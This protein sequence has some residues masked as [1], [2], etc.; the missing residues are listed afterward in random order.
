[1]IAADLWPHRVNAAATAGQNVR[2]CAL[3]QQVPA[4]I[5]LIDLDMVM[6]DLP[7]QVLEILLASWRVNRLSNISAANRIGAES[8]LVFRRNFNPGLQSDFDIF[9]SQHGIYLNHKVLNACLSGR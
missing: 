5:I 1:M 3:Y 9:Q 7:Q 2:A 6:R 4:V 8:T